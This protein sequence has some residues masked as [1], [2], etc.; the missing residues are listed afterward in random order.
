M[1]ST[2][3]REQALIE[4]LKNNINN[5]N[6]E[7]YKKQQE[8]IEVSSKVERLS[9]EK[10]LIKERSK[11]NSDDVKLHD[12]IINLKEQLLDVCT[13]LEVLEKEINEENANGLVISQKLQDINEKIEKI[14]IEKEDNLKKLNLKVR[15]KA[16]LTHKK[17]VL[18]N[19]IENNSN[20]PYGVKNVL[21]NPVLIG[22]H[23]VIG[24]LFETEEKYSTAIDMALLNASSHIVC[25][26]EQ[27]AKDAIRY[28]KENNLGRALFYQSM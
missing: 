26:N 21:N 6:N 13:K 19:S 25:D 2:S 14:S 24:N 7:L 22:I 12:N 4:S 11:Y 20:L 16:E 15:N 23:D 1:L 9:G 18:I 8:L 5:L 28:L 27:A 10:D 3:S 17:E